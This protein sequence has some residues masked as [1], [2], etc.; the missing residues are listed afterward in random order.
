[1]VAT[2]AGSS[3]AGFVDGTSSA[4]MFNAPSGVA[5][6]TNGNVFV[7]DF[8]NNRIRVIGAGINMLHL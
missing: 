2:L 5:V 8:K 3:V 1:M 6:D 7:C 4:A